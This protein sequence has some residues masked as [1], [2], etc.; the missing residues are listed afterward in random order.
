V[1]RIIKTESFG[2]QRTQLMRAIAIALRQLARQNEFG[3]EA[4]DLAAFITMALRTMDQGIEPS[5]AAWE[6]RGYWVKADRF[7]LEW[8][9][10]GKYSDRL[11]KAVMEDDWATVAS[12]AGQIAEKLSGIRISEKNRLGTPWRGA[13]ARLLEDQE[14]RKPTKRGSPPKRIGQDQSFGRC[15]LGALRIHSL[16]VKSLDQVERLTVLTR[17]NDERYFRLFE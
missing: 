11:A 9:W 1:S 8:A 6:K 16:A 3:G 14:R 12:V 4:R 17:S 13:Y 7:R 5:V 10:T 2:K 15:I